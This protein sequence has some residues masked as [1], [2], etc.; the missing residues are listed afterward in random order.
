MTEPLNLMVD[1]DDVLFPLASGLHRKAHEMGLHDNTEEAL[2]V[3]HGWKQYGCSVDQWHEVFDGLIEEDFYR[4]AA[5][6]PGSVESLRELY[7]QDVQPVRINL[8][9]ARGFMGEHAQAIRRFTAEWLEEF[10]V[11]HHTLTF[12]KNKPAAQKDLGNF[13]GALD[14]GTHNFLALIE[15]GVNARLLTV[16]HNADDPVPPYSRVNSVAE[17]TAQVLT[18]GREAA[19]PVRWA[20]GVGQ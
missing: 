3:W 13:D 10:A 16:P 4:T 7:F 18:F 9:T 5:P 1:I 11:P 2:R 8:V 12:A 17:W 14:D 19:W 6:I 20:L 15:G